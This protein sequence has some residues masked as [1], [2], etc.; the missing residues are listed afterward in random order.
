MH[1]TSFENLFERAFLNEA[2]KKFH[3]RK[4]IFIPGSRPY[5]VLKTGNIDEAARLFAAL[6]V[7][8]LRDSEKYRT[9]MTL[10][11]TFH[12]FAETL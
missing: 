3:R 8:D 6:G 5:S 11:S 4:E 10:A 2:V 12:F 9:A 7:F 1:R